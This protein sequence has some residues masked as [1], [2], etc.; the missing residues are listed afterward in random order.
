MFK[1]WF[2]AV[3]AFLLFG[4]FNSAFAKLEVIT[5]NQAFSLMQTHKHIVVVDT[6]AKENYLKGHLPN[7]VNLTN[8][9]LSV[10]RSNVV[11]LVPYNKELEQKLSEFGIKSG[12]TY[13]IYSGENFQKP[14]FF[15]ANATRVTAILYWAGVKNIYYMDGGYEK[16]VDEDKSIQK[17]SYTLPKSNFTIERNRTTVFSFIPFIE[18]A[19]N[20]ENLIQLV[21]ARKYSQFSGKDTNDKRLVRFGHLPGAKWLYVGNYLQKNKNYW[22]IKPKPEIENLFKKAGVDIKKPIIS[23]CN[24]GH[25]ASGLWFIGQAMFDTKLITDYDGSMA[26][27]SRISELPIV[28]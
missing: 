17:G 13:I 26:E 3:L 23:Y 5:T 15:L 9:M 10:K 22:L 11:G 25:L 21:D 19:I 24:T 16:W 20:H 7:A 6:R 28:K 1:K 2:L 8:A 18:W 27:A 4:I 14:Q 12:A